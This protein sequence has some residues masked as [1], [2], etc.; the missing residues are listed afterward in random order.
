M[1]LG[2]IHIAGDKVMQQ[3]LFIKSATSGTVPADDAMVMALDRETEEHLLLRFLSSDPASPV[4][5]I[6]LEDDMASQLL[7]MLAEELQVPV[8]LY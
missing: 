4:R 3:N 6:R 8:G 7:Q 2:L 1:A 5:N